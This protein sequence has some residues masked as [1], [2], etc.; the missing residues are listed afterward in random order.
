[1]DFSDDDYNLRRWLENAKI[2]IPTNELFQI[3]FALSRGGQN[4][5]SGYIVIESKNKRIWWVRTL[6][7]LHALPFNGEEGIPNPDRY[8]YAFTSHPHNIL[9]I[10]ITKRLSAQ[11]IWD[12]I[13]E[14]YALFRAGGKTYKYPLRPAVPAPRAVTTYSRKRKV[15]QRDDGKLQC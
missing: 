2:Y 5:K 7:E 13:E 11:K 14:L 4:Q 9:V 1:M 8:H 10:R 6:D 12:Y 3:F 15:S